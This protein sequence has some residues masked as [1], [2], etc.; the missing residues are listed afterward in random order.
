MS[1][2]SKKILVTYGP[3]WVPVDDM[4]VISNRSTGTLGKLIIGD[5]IKAGAA[6]TALEGPITEPLVSKKARIKKFTFF[7]EFEALFKS[8]IKKGYDVI[9]HAAAV[10]DFRPARR[11]PTKIGS[12]KPLM[13]KL[14]PVPKLISCVKQTAPE[15]LLVG[16]KL[17]SKKSV[18]WLTKKALESIAA[19]RCDLIVA[20]SLTHGY[21]G[22]I[23]D[24]DGQLIGKGRSR[25]TISRQLVNYLREHFVSV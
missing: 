23:I 20:N 19:N 15:S 16:F 9:I 8:E 25:P 22:F 5:L 4:R 14:I 24:H 7:D 21:T 10:A 13:L 12:A 1:L 6:V 11:M 3:T 17:E 2:R 18:Q